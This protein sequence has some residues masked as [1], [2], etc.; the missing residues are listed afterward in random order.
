MTAASCARGTLEGCILQI[1]AREPSYGYA[2]AATLRD[3]GFADVTEG[4]L[5]PL[6]L[7]LERKGLI[8][9]AFRASPA[10]PSRKYYALT[11]E[12]ATYLAEFREAWRATAA[13]VAAIL[14]GEYWTRKE[15]GRC[16]RM[17]TRCW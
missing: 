6:L 1:I 16:N 4:T 11:P 3:G 13:G 14:E 10:G 5:Y 8:A 9:A 15:A 17:N 7:R 2:I 12:G